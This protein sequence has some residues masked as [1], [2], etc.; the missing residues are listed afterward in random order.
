MDEDQMTTSDS[1]DRLEHKI[2][3]LAEAVHAGFGGV[4]KRLTR[5]ET[6]LGE[7]ESRLGS[8][9]TELSDVKTRLTGVERQLVIVENLAVETKK[10]SENVWDSVTSLTRNMEEGFKEAKKDREERFDL[11]HKAIRDWG[12]RVHDLETAR[13]QTTKRRP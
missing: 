9:E 7:V 3:A 12:G 13:T 10:F 4:D 8:V 2:D 5:V 1:M 6:R 11:V